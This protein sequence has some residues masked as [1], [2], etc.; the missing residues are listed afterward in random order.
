MARYKDFLVTLWNGLNYG[1][2]SL[3]VFKNTKN[4]K[5]ILKIGKMTFKAK[6]KKKK[7]KRKN[8]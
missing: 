7:R 5:E 4:G 8:D 1:L 2:N 6:I 3:I